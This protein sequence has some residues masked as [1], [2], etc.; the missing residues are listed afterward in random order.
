MAKYTIELGS[1]VQSGYNVFDDTWNTFVPEHK[2]ELCDKIIRHYWFN[3]IGA[4]TPDRFRHYL[5]EQLALNMAT[6][7]KLYES[8]L[9]DL[10]PLYN[11]IL[12]IERQ[13][14][15]K[16]TGSELSVDSRNSQSIRAIGQSIHRDAFSDKWDKFDG[17]ITEGYHETGNLT[18]HHTENETSHT[19]HDTTVDKELNQTDNRII[20]EVKESK[21]V[22]D[23]DTTEKTTGN[24]T[25]SRTY[26]DY[27]SDT[28]Q[29]RIVN[30]E[31][32]I[33][34][35]YLTEYKHG[36]ENTSRNYTENKTGTDDR[37]TDYTHTIDTQDD[38]TRKITEHNTE[39][40]DEDKTRNKTN[41]DTEDTTK[42]SS[43]QTVTDNTDHTTQKD[44]SHEFQQTQENA[45]TNDAGGSSSEST[46]KT[47]DKGTTKTTGTSGVSRVDLL[48]AYRN[49]LI[50]I[51][52]QIIK[53]LAVNFMGVLT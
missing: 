36:S 24:E 20:K 44:L 30:G 5:N 49:S 29:G 11:Q 6:Y 42:D 22:M 48:V 13:G 38:L 37:T 18:G 25:S 10:M 52:A 31:L 45:S 33:D 32:S 3:E 51:D 47:E 7:N 1:L 39:H 43:K 2:A 15:Q 27:M 4:E 46:G 50:N 26:T 9:W 21:E 28:P 17:K 16:T 35:Q 8:E 53:D 40:F 41:D 14:E 34:A 23:D 19:S 12:E